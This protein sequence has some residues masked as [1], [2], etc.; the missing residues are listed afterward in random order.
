MRVECAEAKPRLESA[1]RS[2]HGALTKHAATPTDA[3][4]QR[5][6]CHFVEQPS[7]LTWLAQT[8]HDARI[9]WRD[10]DDEHVLAGWGTA[11]TLI[12]TTG[13]VSEVLTALGARL[14]MAPSGLRYFGGFAFDQSRPTSPEWAAFGRA[15]FW[16][17]R[18]TIETQQDN[19]VAAVHVLNGDTQQ[20][21]DAL[22][23][24][25][26][27]PTCAPPAPIQRLS[28]DH[29]PKL[30]DWTDGIT[31]ALSAFE[32][33]RLQKVVL[34]RRSRLSLQH[35]TD[36]FEVLRPLAAGQVQTTHFVFQPTG[37]AAFLGCTPERLFCRTANDLKTEALAGTR[38]RGETPQQ[39][40]ELASHLLE[41]PKERNEHA[42]VVEHIRHTLGAHCDSVQG[43]DTPSVRKLHN[44]QHLHTHF[45]AQIRAGVS[46][47]DLLTA[48]HPTPAVCGLPVEQAK[49][50]IRRHESFDRGWY[51]GP[52]GWLS[53]ES[54]DF[55]V[56]IRSALLTADQLWTF[57]GS[58]IV[59]G[60]NADDE[61]A[62]IERKSQPFL[63]LLE[64][65]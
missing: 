29:E 6:E 7:L 41:S 34:A 4:L 47:V 15:R 57:A 30:S 35:P 39:D 53:R 49:H 56:A 37:D 10:R 61:W 17:P 46:D 33:G 25:M 54:A 16:L 32:Q 45:Q 64:H 11:D 31:D 28:A 27:P 59:P 9:Y 60:S 55:H 22:K 20:A 43:E 23:R 40:A 51:A 42:L 48:L 63:T 3:Q 8:P 2:L 18:V 50:F 58:G 13:D 21:A 1:L 24:L 65:R 38:P 52:I 62:E 26:E 14:D 19:W 5:F 36:V 44:V 12:H